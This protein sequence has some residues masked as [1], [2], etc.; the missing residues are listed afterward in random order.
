M[1]DLP[2]K[3]GIGSSSTFL[4]CL[5]QAI[6]AHKNISLN[7]YEMAQEAIRFEQE[8][9]Q[10]NVGLQDTCWAIFGGFNIIEFFQNRDFKITPIGSES[11]IRDLESHLMLFYTG[12]DRSANTVASS[13]SNT[14]TGTNKSVTENII[15]IADN[16]INFILKEKIGEVGE[17]LHESWINKKNLSDKVSNRKIDDMYS[18]A[19]TNGAIGGKLI[20]AGQ[21]GMMLLMVEPQNQNKI[22]ELFFD[23]VYIPFKFEMSGGT[24][25]ILNGT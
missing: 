4:S 18:L 20:G 13:Y 8:V 16:M 6:L 2:S 23:K 12:I 10:E 1:A 19:M 15:R 21:G 14:L 3:S 9:L 7:K 22:K 11:Y 5:L 17:L 25:I 24:K